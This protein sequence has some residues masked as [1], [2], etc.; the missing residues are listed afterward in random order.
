MSVS[1]KR[2][3]EA[4]RRLG[5]AEHDV[6]RRM[7]DQADHVPDPEHMRERAHRISEVGERHLAAARRLEDDEQARTGSDQ[8]QSPG[9][10]S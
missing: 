6:E 5:E 10:G 7:L 8:A 2:L 3:A 1:K 9:S 4:H